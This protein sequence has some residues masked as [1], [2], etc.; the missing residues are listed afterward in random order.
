MIDLHCHILPGID[1][2]APT[3]PVS[4]EMA[5]ASAANGVTTLAC[6]PHILPGLYHNTGPQIT[7]AV[8]QLQQAID[9]QGIPLRLVTGA[10]NHITP[11]FV[12]GLRSGRLLPLAASRYVLVEPP[13]HTPPPRLEEFFFDLAAAGYVPVLTHPERLTWIKSHY[14]AIERLARSGSWMQI[15]AGSLTGAFGRSARYWAERMLDEGLVHIL[16]TDAHNMDRRPPNLMEGYAC[17]EK[18]VGAVEARHLTLTRPE[19]ILTN[20]LPSKLPI[21]GTSGVGLGEEN[22]RAN[23]IAEMGGEMHS[24]S[25]RDGAYRERGLSGRLRNLFRQRG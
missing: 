17:A 6:T 11:G 9:E 22:D 1:D 5:R 2:G 18:R 19:G 16:A 8:T 13:H 23:P 14:P 7:L 15:T 3:F 4:L 25:G 24:A 10:D 21:P 12:A 20:D